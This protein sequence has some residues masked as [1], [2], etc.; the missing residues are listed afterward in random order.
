[1]ERGRG[2]PGKPLIGLGATPKTVEDEWVGTVSG[3]A[4]IGRTDEL[5]RLHECC[6]GVSEGAGALVL[7]DGDAGFGKTRLL[8]EV[9][10]APLLPRGYAA[11][12]AGAL[13]YARAPYAPIRDL[14]VSLDKRF[15]KVLQNNRALA[16]QLQAV[17]EFR[18]SVPE[19][20]DS[21]Q[22]RRLLDAIVQAISLYAA[23]SPIVLTLEDVHW[24]DS[25]S[26]DV[27]MHLSRVIP[28]MRTLLLVSFRPVEARA[29]ERAQHL[30]AQLSRNAA[31]SLSLKPLGPADAMLLID[32]VADAALPMNVRR[33]IREM[34]D[35]NPLLLIE[36]AKLAAEKP[37][38]LTSGLPLSL[39]AIVAERLASFDASDVDVLR[40]AAV[41]GQF[42]P[43]MLA[44]IA[45][46]DHERIVATL[47]KARDASIVAEQGERSAPFV[48][49]HALI[50]HAITEDLLGFEAEQL[51]AR[52][53]QRLEREEPGAH[54]HSR[55]AHHYHH[56]RISEKARAYNE[57]AGAEAL[58]V[59]AYAD[60]VQLLERAVDGRPLDE[61]TR[62]LYKQLSDAHSGAH[63]PR[64]AA[65]ITKGLFELAVRC[66]D[67]QAI[68]DTGFA[69]ARQRYQLLDD[70]GA[71]AIAR[72][73]CEALDAVRYPAL[74]FNLYSTLAWYLA[75]LRRTDEAAQV[76]AKAQ[77]LREH[78]DGPGLV[79]FYE[80]SGVSKV[81]ADGGLSYRGDIEAALAIARDLDPH[82]YISRLDTAIAI[83]MASNID[84]MEFARIQTE[85][86]WD[87]AQRVPVNI[88]AGQLAMS[89]W[90]TF[91]R[92]ET[93]QA[94]LLIGKAIPFAEEAPLLSFSIACTG[95]PIALHTDDSLLL[96]QCGRPRL[97]EH[98][99]ASNTPNVFGPVAA[100]VAGQLRTQG[101]LDE[102]RTLLAHAVR[103]LH[104]A[105]N[106]VP[107]LIESAR[108][109][110]PE[111]MERGIVLLEALRAASRSA[112][113]GW[114]L[115]RAYAA[116]GDERRR[117]AALAAQLFAEIP[118]VPYQA[119]SAELA[120]ESDAALELYRR[121]GFSADVQRLESAGAARSNSGLSKREF[122]VAGLVAEGRS[123]RSIAETLSL[124]ERTV[125]NHIAS[126][127]G[128]L[129]LRSRA[130]VAAFMARRA[131]P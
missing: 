112:D 100:A 113:A 101:R 122:E 99:F 125:E 18:P 105:R 69:Y 13:D 14:L 118:W 89:A 128:K 80:A 83:A 81:H 66:D 29:D 123:N 50:R 38:A 48:F 58:K 59:Y 30:L 46:V 67:Q 40:V 82:L 25:A 52:I 17:I 70:E 91:L 86:L 94:R 12:S 73:A 11:V 109:A 6:R 16:A 62:A 120:G 117:Y 92:G 116:A 41:L 93:A 28:A 104:D 51:H 36:F 31:L 10:K 110:A 74:A 130:E 131:A 102:A 107:L 44:E 64:E 19:A 124:S 61:T 77:A 35:G 97:L 98:A 47:R 54:L 56:A 22:Q 127:F 39:K 96:R 49:R 85:R 106:N 75:Q 126:I 34:A 88:I 23:Q 72:Q 3:A 32:D 71:L 4:L 57:I 24:I 42:D 55:L 87:L 21:A 65:E 9:M 8:A 53:A 103:K 1:M 121:C 37:D 119:E 68:A 60:A 7:I 27:L 79:R 5:N 90:N 45:G 26:A 20:D 43:R 95:I 2:H 84:D 15:P 115:A 114:H 129:S 63:R 108:C 76:L 33:S 78:G 111:A